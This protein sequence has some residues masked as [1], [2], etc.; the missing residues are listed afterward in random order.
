MSTRGAGEREPVARDCSASLKP[1]ALHACLQ[2][3]RRVSV[4]VTGESR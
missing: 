1:A 3:N 2:P 4:D